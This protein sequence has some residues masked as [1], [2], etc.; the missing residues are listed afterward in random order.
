MSNL[1]SLR[2]DLIELI[3]EGAFR[4][5]FTDDSADAAINAA[6][7]QIA[8]TLGLT[9]TD[10]RTGVTAKWVTLPDDVISIVQVAISGSMVTYDPSGASPPLPLP[11]DARD[12]PSGSTVVVKDGSYLSYP[13]VP[14]E[15]WIGPGGV[16]YQGGDAFTMPAEDVILYARWGV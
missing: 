11:V 16:L 6:C 4:R 3:G 2:A 13:D 7:D 5:T 14:F 15:A 8:A 10:V 1:A 12:H 9:R